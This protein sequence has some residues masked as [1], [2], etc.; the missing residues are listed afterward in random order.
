MGGIRPVNLK[1]LVIWTIIGT[2][3]SSVVTQLL[4]VREFLT[5]FHGNEITISLVLFCWLLLTG[6]G[7]LAARAVHRPSLTTYVLLNFVI[8]IW[9]LLQMIGVREFREAFFTHGV[10]PGFYSIFLYI[11]IAIAPYCLLVGFI[12]PYAQKV[13]NHKYYSFS[14]GELYL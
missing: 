9:P 3:V 10:S 5:Q 6:V 2:G 13:L 12:L 4:T 14:S 7:S 1:R 8:A 11:L